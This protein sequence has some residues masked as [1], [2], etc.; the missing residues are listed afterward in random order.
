M[1]VS[2]QE[3]L[4][5]YVSDESQGQR[6]KKRSKTRDSRG[7][8]TIVEVCPEEKPK[9][10][11]S[12]ADT[13]IPDVIGSVDQLGT[14]K[15]KWKVIES[16]NEDVRDLLESG[17]TVSFSYDKSLEATREFPDGSEKDVKNHGT[18][19]GDEKGARLKKHPSA[20]DSGE[21]EATVYRDKHGR[22]IN[23]EKEKLILKERVQ[24]IEEGRLED[25]VW[26]K[27]IAQLLSAKEGA[28]RLKSEAVAPF[29]VYKGDNEREEE[30]KM[31]IRWGDPISASMTKAGRKKEGDQVYKGPEAPPNRFNIAPGYRWDGVDRSNGFEKR[32][33]LVQ[34]RK[35]AESHDAYAWSC[36][37]L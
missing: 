24:K 31:R 14:H 30:L 6:K 18:D 7:N 10:K 26:K 3:Y 36:E 20:I 17:A 27:G 2:L 21:G 28:E 35:L 9:K 13:S 32:F 33:F 22:K 34:N 12:R 4:K 29:S 37:D 5:K 8:V 11:I 25:L 16:L 23:I 1:S 15:D 19:E